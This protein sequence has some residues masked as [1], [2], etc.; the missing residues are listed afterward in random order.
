MVIGSAA[1]RDRMPPPGYLLG[2]GFAVRL[3]REPAC[4]CG[5]R[6]R[7][8]NARRRPK[9]SGAGSETALPAEE[10]G[11]RRRR[12]RRGAVAD[13]AAELR[14]HS[15]GDL[16]RVTSDEHSVKRSAAASVPLAFFRCVFFSLAFFS[17]RKSEIFFFNHYYSPVIF[18]CLKFCGV[19]WKKKNWVISKN[20]EHEDFPASETGIF[21]R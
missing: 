11:R 20:N 19:L 4:I 21:S 17:S 8:R 14:R 12:G 6:I 2:V 10:P 13:A 3:G 9:R 16:G 18:L 1:L 7:S 5:E 15:R